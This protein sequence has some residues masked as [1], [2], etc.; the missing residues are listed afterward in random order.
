MKFIKRR[1]YMLALT[2]GLAQ[3]AA[4]TDG[5]PGII[6]ISS[7]PAGVCNSMIRQGIEAIAQSDS[8]ALE[9][10][11]GKT[12]VAIAQASDGINSLGRQPE[13]TASALAY[14]KKIYEDAWLQSI[15]EE[16]KK[17]VA[18]RKSEFE[19]A[20]ALGAFG[21]AYAMLQKK[22]VEDKIPGLKLRPTLQGTI[23]KNKAVTLSYMQNRLFDAAQFS[24]ALN[25]QDQYDLDPETFAK[26]F[27]QY[28]PKSEAK[29]GWWPW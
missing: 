1:V 21:C 9:S 23:E 15:A 22:M 7:T 3:A 5:I 2:A 26:L 25:L 14:R 16:V 8:A 20:I 11:I 10:P 24:M 4:S 28:V 19:R 12:Y 18:E 17:L 29:S 27:S 13:V 6:V